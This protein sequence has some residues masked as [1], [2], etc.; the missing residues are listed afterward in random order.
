MMLTAVMR[1]FYSMLWLPRLWPGSA[2]DAERTATFDI[3]HTTRSLAKFTFCLAVADSR[4][5]NFR[6]C[7]GLEQAGHT[8]DARLHR[9][10]NNRWSF[11]KLLAEC[12]YFERMVKKNLHAHRVLYCIFDSCLRCANHQDEFSRVKNRANYIEVNDRSAA[13]RSLRSFTSVTCPVKLQQ[14]CQHRGQ[15]S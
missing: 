4:S 8:C 7:A 3:R 1:T 12:R 9:W 6:A 15:V 10:R 5:H 14:F 13:K 2:N 11:R